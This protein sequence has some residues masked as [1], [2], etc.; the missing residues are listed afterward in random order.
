M[1]QTTEPPEAQQRTAAGRGRKLARGGL[2]PARVTRTGGLLR[3]RPGL[4]RHR[5]LGTRCASEKGQEKEDDE[6]RV[7]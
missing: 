5:L 2:H 1:Q 6:E 7:S 3:V 4:E